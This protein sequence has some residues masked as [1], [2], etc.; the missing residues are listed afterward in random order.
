MHSTLT[1]PAIRI[2]AKELIDGAHDAAP[3]ARVMD[4]RRAGRIVRTLIVDTGIGSI[5]DERA[6]FAHGEDRESPVDCA[7]YE[8]RADTDIT[9]LIQELAA[10]LLA[11]RDNG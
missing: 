7:V 1:R 9:A 11:S 5:L 2:T 6:R 4:N 8:V 10:Q 3:A